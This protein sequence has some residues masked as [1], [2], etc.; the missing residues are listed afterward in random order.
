MGEMG[1]RELDTCLAKMFTPSKIKRLKRFFRMQNTSLYTHLVK[2]IILLAC[3][4]VPTVL[5]TIWNHRISGT[6]PTIH[7]HWIAG[8]KTQSRLQLLKT[9]S[10]LSIAISLNSILASSTFVILD[11][12]A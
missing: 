4:T 6:K 3:R 12:K 5:I 8:P 1:E 2:A 11:S 9:V 7:F 10:I